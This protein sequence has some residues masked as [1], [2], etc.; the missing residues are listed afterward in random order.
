MWMTTQTWTS[1]MGRGR[2]TPTIREDD[3]AKAFLA[4]LK[5]MVAKAEELA[6]A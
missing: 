2:T 3:V 1:S 4:E 6:T 5:G